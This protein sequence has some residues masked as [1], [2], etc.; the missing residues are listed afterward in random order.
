MYLLRSL[1]AA[2]PYPSCIKKRALQESTW[3]DDFLRIN[4]E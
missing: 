1:T 3:S 2:E 4:M